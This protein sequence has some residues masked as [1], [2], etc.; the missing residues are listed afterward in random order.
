MPTAKATNKLAHTTNGGSQSRM[1]GLTEVFTP[2]QVAQLK[3][4]VELLELR[5]RDFEAQA[6]IAEARYRLSELQSRMRAQR[7]ARDARDEA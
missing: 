5:A 2:E 7:L 6:R 1:L 4:R 3:D